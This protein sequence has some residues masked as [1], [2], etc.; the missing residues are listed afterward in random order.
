MVDLLNGSARD[1]GE[2]LER[3]AE[4]YHNAAKGVIEVEPLPAQPVLLY[5]S[6]IKEDADD[7]ENEGL[8]RFYGIEGVAVRKNN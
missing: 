1:Y 5:F 3:R 4:L 8:S 2:A 7:W 6:D